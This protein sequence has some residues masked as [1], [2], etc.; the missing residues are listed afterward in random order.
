[1]KQLLFIFLIASIS[2]F[3]QDE[4][5]LLKSSGNSKVVEAHD[6]G[7]LDWG[8]IL[9]FDGITIVDEDSLQNLERLIKE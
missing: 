9:D 4:K 7:W 8:L 6:I 3:S 5:R 2:L 1:M